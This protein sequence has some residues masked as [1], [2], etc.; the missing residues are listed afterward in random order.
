M[1]SLL[2]GVAG[3]SGVGKSY[4]VRLLTSELR[5]AV[6]IQADDFHI[7]GRDERKRRGISPLNPVASDLDGMYKFLKNLKNN[8]TAEK[9]VY[10]HKTGTALSS[11]EKIKPA[12]FVICEGLLPFHTRK[13][14][15]L[16]GLKIFMEAEKELQVLWKL[17]RDSKRGYSKEFDL[18]QRISDYKLYVEPQ[19]KLADILVEPYQAKYFRGVGYRLLFRKAQPAKLP[20]A[21]EPKSKYFVSLVN[22]KDTELAFEGALPEKF[23]AKSPARAA[24]RI[25]AK[26]IRVLK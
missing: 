1:V 9:P 11:F 19:K 25:I 23:G 7:Y 22:G 17:K 16:F 18:V 26:Q 2:I 6:Q 21:Y 10:N 13:L 20:L 14:A 3:D 4:F 15:R 8:R 24:A 5:N 12:K